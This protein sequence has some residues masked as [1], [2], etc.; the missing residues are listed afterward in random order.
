MKSR[1]RAKKYHDPDYLKKETY[2]YPKIDGSLIQL[3]RERRIDSSTTGDL[4]EAIRVIMLQ[5]G[6]IKP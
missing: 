4:E 3:M 6:Y 1:E 5:H 2:L